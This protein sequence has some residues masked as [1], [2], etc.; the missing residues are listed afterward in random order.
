MF[1]CIFP[2]AKLPPIPPAF[3]E[4]EAQVMGKHRTQADRLKS[5][6]G[7]MKKTAS[8]VVDEVEA[9]KATTECIS[10]SD[11]DGQ[12]DFLLSGVTELADGDISASDDEQPSIKSKNPSKAPSKTALKPHSHIHATTHKRAPTEHTPKQ[13]TPIRQQALNTPKTKIHHKTPSSPRRILKAMK[14]TP[15]LDEVEKDSDGKDL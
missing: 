4:K 10:E 5:I 1:N 13:H 6:L 11:D 9:K 15:Q 8:K 3:K 2:E 7:D 12:E 14:R